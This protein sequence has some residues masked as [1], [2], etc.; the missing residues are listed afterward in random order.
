MEFQKR[1]QW[2]KRLPTREPRELVIPNPKLKLMD[3]VREV[4]RRLRV[5]S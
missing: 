1:S 2:E 3:Q 4:E 5:E